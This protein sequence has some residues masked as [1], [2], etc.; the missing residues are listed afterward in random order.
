MYPSKV[1]RDREWENSRASACGHPFSPLPCT[2]ILH[3]SMEPARRPQMRFTLLWK[4]S[5]NTFPVRL[6]DKLLDEQICLILNYDNFHITGIVTLKTM[7]CDM[8]KGWRSVAWVLQPS[9]VSYHFYSSLTLTRLC[10]G[11]LAYT[12]RN[13]HPCVKQTLLDHATTLSA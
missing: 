9:S 1:E 6:W 13:P 11:I 2:V 7:Q 10:T 8:Y 5:V 12:F 3:W 4:T